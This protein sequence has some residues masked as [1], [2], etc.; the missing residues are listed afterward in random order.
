MRPSPE[1]FT[2][3]ASPSCTTTPLK[4]GLA[5]CNCPRSGRSRPG[6]AASRGWPSG[7]RMPAGWRGVRLQRG[8]CWSWRRSGRCEVGSDPL[9]GL[10]FPCSGCRCSQLQALKLDRAD[11]EHRQAIPGH[12]IGGS[13]L[14]AGDAAFNAR[15]HHPRQASPRGQAIANRQ[16]PRHQTTRNTPAVLLLQW[17]GLAEWPA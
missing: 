3:A 8:L 10:I 13:K 9:Y 17:L 6:G 7:W 2:G 12:Q 1:R 4:P 15:A 14:R 16:P 11:A 5:G